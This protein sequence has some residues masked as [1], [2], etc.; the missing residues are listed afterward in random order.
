MWR[1]EGYLFF[2]LVGRGTEL[3][4]SGL[5]ASAKHLVRL[6]TWLLPVTVEAGPGF[7]SVTSPV[8]QHT[9]QHLPR[10]TWCPASA[11]LQKW[12]QQPRTK[13]KA[14]HLLLT[15]KGRDT[16]KPRRQWTFP[17][18]HAL[19]ML[20]SRTEDP[21]AVLLVPT[22]PRLSVDCACF[23]RQK[24]NRCPIVRAR[25]FLGN[26]RLA[27]KC[28]LPHSHV[29]LPIFFLGLSADPGLLVG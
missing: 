7:S 22:G 16:L 4:L 29:S 5:A 23:N 15:G 12:R 11:C 27:S 25:H 8:R 17:A 21:R 19:R 14:W 2:H 3:I 18:L 9:T 6:V 20:L 26:R 10:F 1:S 24:D 13:A 28:D